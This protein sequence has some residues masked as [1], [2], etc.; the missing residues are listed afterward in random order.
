MLLERLRAETRL[1]HAR[2]EDDL[3]TMRAHESLDRHVVLLARFFGFYQVWEPRLRACLADEAFFE[4]RRK[5]HLLEQDLAALGLAPEQIRVLPRCPRLPRL[6]STAEAMGSFYVLEGATL[7]GQVISRRLERSLGLSA[8]L[9]YS[10]F[11]SYGREVGPMWRA[12]GE[13]LLATSSTATENAC[14]RSA[15]STFAR[16]HLWL[17]RGA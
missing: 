8:G 3:A 10:F 17:C 13:R 15:Q 2:I 6:T 9:G 12:F 5:L 4:P 16:L 14:I 1:L 11:R 7:G